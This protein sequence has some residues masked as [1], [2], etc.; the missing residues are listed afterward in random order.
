MTNQQKSIL[1]LPVNVLRRCPDSTV[2][3]LMDIV[4]TGYHKQVVKY[5][6]V[7][8]PRIHELGTFFSDLGLDI[9]DCLMYL[10]VDDVAGVSSEIDQDDCISVSQYKLYNIS[11]PL[12]LLFTQEN[13]KST[14]AYRPLPQE[15]YPNSYEMTG[16]TSSGKGCGLETFNNT[17]AHFKQ[18]YNQCEKLVIKVIIEHEL[19]TYYERKMGFVELSRALQKRCDLQSSGFEDSFMVTQDFNVA[20]MEKVL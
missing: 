7:Q 11:Q 3:G 9:D 8:T 15:K 4:N 17:L 6:I 19:V 10:M 1:A 2:Q 16:F 18:R 13:V 20:S 12:P 5:N 14:L